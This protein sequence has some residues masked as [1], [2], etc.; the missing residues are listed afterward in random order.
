[1]IH[2]EVQIHDHKEKLEK[3]RQLDPRAGEKKGEPKKMQ[4]WHV[5]VRILTNIFL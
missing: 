3:E 5:P 4:V 1:M 2:M